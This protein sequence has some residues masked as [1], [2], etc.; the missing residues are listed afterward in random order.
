MAE[1]KKARAQKILA[2]LENTYKG[3]RSALRFNSVF[4]LL[5]AVILSA[6][7]TDNQVNRITAGLFSRYRDA[8]AFAKLSPE[9]LEPLIQTC[10]LYKSKAKNIIA[11]SR[12]L[13]EK[14]HG[15]VPDSKEALLALPG[16]GN[17]T[18]NVILAVGF[19]IPA[20]AVDTHVF[21][22]ANRLG[23]AQAQTP[24]QTEAAL[25][26]LIPKDQWADA[27]HWLLWHGRLVCS[28][29]NPDCE[30]CPLKELC[31]S[32]ITVKGNSAP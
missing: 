9:E 24:D 28:A 32:R 26:A 10:G 11:A 16:V 20:L 8:A 13:V 7:T 17:K 12:I 23:L 25:R 4:Q 31:P 1:G 22:V 29:R 14:Y 18:A 5:V 19:G 2:I 6:Q 3:R 27:H 30:N 15:E 21:R